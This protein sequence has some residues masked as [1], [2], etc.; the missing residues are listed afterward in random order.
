MDVNPLDNGRQAFKSVLDMN[1]GKARRHFS[2][3]SGLEST[4][5]RV[6]LSHSFNLDW[7]ITCRTGAHWQDK[8]P[9]GLLPNFIHQVQAGQGPFFSFIVLPLIERLR[10]SIIT[11]GQ[12]ITFFI[13]H[14]NHPPSSFFRKLE[15]E[16]TNSFFPL[17][18]VDHTLEVSS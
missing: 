11:P 7:E 1:G 15:S 9:A 12:P 16:R 4:T 17:Y 5:G 6:P 2:P 13:N 10:K 3:L 14:D 18:K 8:T